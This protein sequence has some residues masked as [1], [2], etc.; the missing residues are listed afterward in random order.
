MSDTGI[1]I[2]GFFTFLLLG[3]GFTFSVL[4]IQRLGREAVAKDGAQQR[5]SLR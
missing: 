2:V 4:E 5:A 1:F 3:G